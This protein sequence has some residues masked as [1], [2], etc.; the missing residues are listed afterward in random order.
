MQSRLKVIILTVIL[1]VAF[2]AEAAVLYFGTDRALRL[3]FGLLMLG[4]ILWAASRLGVVE[5]ASELLNQRAAVRQFGRLRALVRQ[6]LWEIR[7]LNWM[8]VDVERGS[9]DR[10]KLIQE[11]NATE[12]RLKEIIGQIRSAAGQTDPGNED[13]QIG[14]D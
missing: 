13:A 14:E 10:E 5:H 6:L 2:S 4:P 8:A 1:A 11:L 3:G 7:R 12:N 9:R